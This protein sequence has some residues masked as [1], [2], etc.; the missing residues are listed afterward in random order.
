M[1]W[2]PDTFGLGTMV[3]GSPGERERAG[4][5]KRHRTMGQKDSLSD[6]VETQPGMLQNAMTTGESHQEV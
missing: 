1:D 2:E 5:G 4:E 3:L 6:T